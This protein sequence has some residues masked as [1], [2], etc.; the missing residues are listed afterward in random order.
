MMAEPQNIQNTQVDDSLEH[1]VL[2]SEVVLGEILVAARTEKE[3]SQQDVA[4]NLRFSVK[5]VDALENNAFDLLPGATITRGFIR[6]YARLLEIDAEPLLLSY[7]LLFPSGISKDIAIKSSMRPVQLT[8]ESLPWLKY[9]LGSIL[10]LLFLMAWIFYVD[11]MPK[12]AIDANE[13]PARIAVPE[14]SALNKATVETQIPLP[15]IALPMAERELDTADVTVSSVDG[16]V[17]AGSEAAVAG[18]KSTQTDIAQAQPAGNLTTEVN[19]IDIS[20]KQVTMFFSEQA[21]AKVTDKSGKVIYQK[22][23]QQGDIETLSGN[24]PFNFIIGNAKATKLS[25][26]GQ[27]IDLTAYT[28]N[29]VARITLE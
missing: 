1:P 29:N 13:K 19:E 12:F 21:W 20:H 6:N 26:S 17:V 9:I 14:S 7:N 28:K 15:E 8:K 22:T 2:T 23:S 24:P 10:I 27:E 18:L 5:Q 16:A 11:Y 3:L 25:L 4:N